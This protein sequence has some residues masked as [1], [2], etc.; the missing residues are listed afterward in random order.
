MNGF[1]CKI[2]S[3]VLSSA[4]CVT[5]A[6]LTRTGIPTCAWPQSTR[7]WCHSQLFWQGKWNALIEANDSAV[8]LLIRCLPSLSPPWWIIRSP[9]SSSF[10]R[11]SFAAV[12]V[13][14]ADT[15]LA[16]HNGVNTSP[17]QLEFDWWQWQ[18]WGKQSAMQDG[19]RWVRGKRGTWE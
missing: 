7:V 14:V 13:A 8:I 2:P 4:C 16:W 12:V 1:M 10:C 18:G 9:L 19:E 3:Y 15:E 11:T 6:N 17:A 5:M